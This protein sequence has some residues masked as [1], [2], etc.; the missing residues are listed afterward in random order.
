M[1]AISWRVQELATTRGLGARALADSAGLDEKTV[2]NILA[3][4]ATRVDLETI[5]RLSRALNVRPGALWETDPDPRRAWE[6][7]AGTAGHARADELEAALA[8]ARSEHVDPALERA[9]RTP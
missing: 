7:T 8:G 4:R 2:R 3:G 1:A 5:A 6:Q 9:S